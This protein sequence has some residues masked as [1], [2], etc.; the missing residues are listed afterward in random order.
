MTLKK[1][2]EANFKVIFWHLQKMKGRR[3]GRQKRKKEK[4]FNWKCLCLGQD[5]K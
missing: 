2:L 3:E 4:V 5:S 1:K